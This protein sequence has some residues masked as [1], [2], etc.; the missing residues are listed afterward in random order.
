LPDAQD[1]FITRELEQRR[2]FLCTDVLQ[3]LQ[4]MAQSNLLRTEEVSS[5]RVDATLSGEGLRTP[6][7]RLVVS[8]SIS[9]TPLTATREQT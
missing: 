7:S 6:P 2:E 9:L 1:R 5:L 8:E 4:D 3:V